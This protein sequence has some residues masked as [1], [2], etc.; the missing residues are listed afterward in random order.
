MV[1]WSHMHSGDLE[2]LSHMSLIPGHG[3]R[4]NWASIWGNGSQM[5]G[6]SDRRSPLTNKF[7]WKAHIVQIKTNLCLHQHPSVAPASPRL[8][9]SGVRDFII[10]L[11]CASSSPRGRHPTWSISNSNPSLVPGS[12]S[13]LHTSGRDI[14]NWTDRVCKNKWIWRTLERA[15]GRISLG[16]TDRI[17]LYRYRSRWLKNKFTLDCH[18]KDVNISR[19]WWKVGWCHGRKA[20]LSVIAIG[21]HFPLCSTWHRPSAIIISITSK[22]VEFFITTVI[23]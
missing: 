2:I 1:Q 10:Q 3:L 16:R 19:L 13:C 15:S 4:G 20:S 23:A 21:D 17:N 5:D 7:L 14:V 6:L 12:P 11:Q 18:C 8:S 22:A 9:A